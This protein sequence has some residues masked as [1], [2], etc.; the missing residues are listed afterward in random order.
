MKLRVVQEV[1]R[2]ELS[3]HD[4]VLKY[5]I[6]IEKRGSFTLLETSLSKK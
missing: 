6:L 4:E 1:E 5:G 3:Q 2:G